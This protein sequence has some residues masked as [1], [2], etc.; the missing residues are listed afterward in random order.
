MLKMI[1]MPFE[2]ISHTKIFGFIPL[3]SVLHILL[4]HLILVGLMKFKLSYKKSMA[5]L[6]ALAIGKEIFDSFTLTNRIEENILDFSLSL[7]LP[8]L[9]GLSR[10]AIN[11]K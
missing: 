3:D 9:L 5:V 4:G 1:R 2:Y 8:T 10:L 6:I 11:S 7:L